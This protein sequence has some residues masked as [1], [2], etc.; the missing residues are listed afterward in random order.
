MKAMA[1]RRAVPV[2]ALILAGTTLTSCG[3]NAEGASASG[4][5]APS[6]AA[7]GSGTSA[8]ASAP[9][10]VGGSDGQS[11]GAGSDGGPQP[12]TAA[13]LKVTAANFDTGDLGG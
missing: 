11:L 7:S 12:C 8:G 3:P 10:P 2:L 4:A 1:A 13:Q 5:P 9:T 6:S